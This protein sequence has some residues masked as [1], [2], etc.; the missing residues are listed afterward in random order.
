MFASKSHTK[1]YFETPFLMIFKYY[2]WA[3]YDLI[4]SSICRKLETWTVL[5]NLIESFK[6]SQD[7][8]CHRNYSNR[9]Y[10]LDSCTCFHTNSQRLRAEKLTSCNGN[11]EYIQRFPTLL[12]NGPERNYN[13]KT[14]SALVIGNLDSSVPKCSF[15][16][17][18][19]P[20]SC[21]PSIWQTMGNTQFLLVTW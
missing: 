3:S 17:V 18:L 16:N 2:A 9:T 19:I 12:S 15:L 13:K 1:T 11:E 8:R 5:K 10:L 4:A 7:V 21:S 6:N 14:S 20:R